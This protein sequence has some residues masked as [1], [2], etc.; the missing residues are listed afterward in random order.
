MALPQDFLATPA[1]NIVVDRIDFAKTC[2]PEYAGRYAVVLDNVLNEAECQQLI[3]AAEATTNGEW[4]RAMV[5]IGGGR[6]ALYADTRNC[7]RIIMDSEELVDKVWQRIAAIPDVQEI[8]ELKNCPI[9]FGNGPRK[10]EE[11]WR[12]SRPNERMRFL[13]Y[14]GGEFFRAHCDGSYERDDRSER[15]Y[16]TL[17]LYLNNS[18]SPSAE[19]IDKM[20]PA[21]R[22]EAAKS[23]LVG[24][25]TTFHCMSCD[26]ERSLDVLPRTGRVLL[27]QHRDLLHSGADVIQGTKYTMRTDLMYSL[28]SSKSTTKSSMKSLLD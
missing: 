2:L 27:F 23:T 24:G 8:M 26:P 6:Q 15:S 28:E 3:E 1:P 14:Q 22:L 4:E 7:G 12:F 11:V 13:K 25:A 21:E 18:D 10:R 19:E 16:F 20:S 9:Y 17:H 5:N